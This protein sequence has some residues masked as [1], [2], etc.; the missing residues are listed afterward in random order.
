MNKDMFSEKDLEQIAAKGIS[1][2]KLAQQIKNFEEGFPFM[3]LSKAA[4]I[5][6]GVLRFN[7]KEADDLVK[8]YEDEMPN[9]Q[10]YKF[11]PASGAA[12]R[13]FKSLFAFMEKYDGSEQAKKDFESDDSF[14]SIFN[15]FKNIKQFAFYKDLKNAISKSGGNI[16]DLINKKEYGQ[17]I[18]YLLTSAGLN[19]G[20]LPKGLLEFHQYPNATRTPLE[21][22]LVEG[23]NYCRDIDGKVDIHFTV[24]PEHKALFRQKVKDAG[25]PFANEYQTYFNAYFSEQQSYTDTIAVDLNN[26]PFRLD[27]GNIL[28]RPA[29]HGA[30]LENLNTIDADIVFIKNIDNVVP[31]NMKSTTYR[32]KKLLAGVL[33]QYQ[34]RIFDYLKKLEKVENVSEGLVNEV[35]EFLQKDLSNDFT[36]RFGRMHIRERANFLLQ[37]LNRPIRVCG[38][39]KNEGEPGGGPFWSKN[40]DNTFSLQIV[41]SSQINKE[42]AGQAE[43]LQKSSHFN[44]VDLVCGLKDCN[45]NKFNLLEF[46]DPKTGFVTMKSKD[47][48]ELKAQELPGLWNGAMADWNAIFVEVPIETFNPVKIVNDLLR[49]QHQG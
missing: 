11:V 18:R 3:E 38:M 46:R 20:S 48:R 40:A 31:D 19:Y 24:S 14:G 28:F 23:A 10:I 25:Q 8:L 13:M 27:N 47:G 26:Q 4:T 35:A 16:D 45:G 36:S 41:E 49:P 37:K 43:I 15:F 42:D 30:L 9:N 21:E 1:L 32:Y 39:V 33:L 29:G 22:H 5:G 7:G 34:K 17:V 2:E 12:S 44:P 6:D